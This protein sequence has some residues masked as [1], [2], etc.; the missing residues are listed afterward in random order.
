MSNP[1]HY[2]NK[3]LCKKLKEVG[4]PRSKLSLWD[5]ESRSE[6]RERT[7]DLSE[8]VSKRSRELFPC[9]DVMEMLD[10]F[11][12]ETGRFILSQY[13]EQSEYNLPDYLAITIIIGRTTKKMEF[14]T[15]LTTGA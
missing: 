2:P 4:F 3:N 1:L 12:A 10:E 11:P 13:A 7:F 5:S 14:L 8:F 9:P 15:K 6:I